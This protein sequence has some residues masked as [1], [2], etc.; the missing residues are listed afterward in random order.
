[1]RELLYKNLTSLDHKKRD[2]IVQEVVRKDGVLAKTSRRCL[3]FIKEK[4]RVQSP[5]DLKRIADLKAESEKAKRHFHV[6]K[7]RDSSSGK[8]KLMC[9]VAGTFYAMVNNY[10]Y[11]IVFIHTFKISF[12]EAKTK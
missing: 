6:L 5:E 2:I 3:Y 9:K 1:M 4:V 7:E 8:D 12:T 10:L 11:S